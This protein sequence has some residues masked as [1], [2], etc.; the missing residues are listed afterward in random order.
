MM[1]SLDR[2]VRRAR[3]VRRYHS[4]QVVLH[5]ECFYNG[6]CEP[7]DETERR[8]REPAG[9]I[10]DAHRLAARELL[11][12]ELEQRKFDETLT[13][14]LE[15]EEDTLKD[16][17][18]VLLGVDINRILKFQGDP[19]VYRTD[20]GRG[21]ITLGTIGE[22]YRQATFREAVRAATNV[23]TPKVSGPVWRD[24]VQAIWRRCE[25]V[26]AG[27]PSHPAQETRTWLRKYL[28]CRGVT[29]EEE[30]QNAAQRGVPFLEER[31]HPD[32][33]P[34]L[35]KVAGGE[36]G[37]GPGLPRPEAGRR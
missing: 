26:G 22:T 9:Y 30:W 25:D 17:L 13:Q 19:P 21:H 14:P 3:L 6:L 18:A 7:L 5:V 24:L 8:I 36:A 35:Q 34:G 16:P 28:T 1:A 11:R 31:A 37:Q 20:T 23:V 2:D 27:D 32:F 15:D 29:G 4:R 12:M 10:Q 33:P